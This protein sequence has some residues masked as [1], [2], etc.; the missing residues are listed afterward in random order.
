MTNKKGL[1]SAQKPLF[2]L[3]LF[4]LLFSGLE[5]ALINVPIALGK[6]PNVPTQISPLILTNTPHPKIPSNATNQ[7]TIISNTTQLPVTSSSTIN[8]SSLLSNTPHPKISSNTTTTPP[9]PQLNSTSPK[10]IT[11]SSLLSN[12]PHPKILSNSSK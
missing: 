3:A 10:A 6:S 2:I 4:M 1:S 5:I 7:K 8:S 9:L 11:N 12:T